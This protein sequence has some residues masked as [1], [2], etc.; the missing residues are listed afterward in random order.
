[1]KKAYQTLTMEVL[2]VECGQQVLQGS[3]TKTKIDVNSVSVEPYIKDTGFANDEGQNFQ[4]ISFD[5]L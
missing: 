2:Q 3:L 5:D 4:S 1:M